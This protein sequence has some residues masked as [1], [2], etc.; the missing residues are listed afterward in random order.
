[1]CVDQNWASYDPLPSSKRLPNKCIKYAYLH[2]PHTVS[3]KRSLPSD[4]AAF[5]KNF[6][7][8]IRHAFSYSLSSHPSLPPLPASTPSPPSNPPPISTLLRLLLCQCLLIYF[9]F[10][11]LSSSS[12]SSSFYSTTPVSAAS[13]SSPFHHLQLL[14]QRLLIYFLF[15]GAS[16]ASSSSSSVSLQLRL[17]VFFFFHLRLFLQLLILFH[18]LLL[19]RIWILILCQIPSSYAKASSSVF[20]RVCSHRAF[21]FIT[22]LYISFKKIAFNVPRPWWSNFKFIRQPYVRCLNK[23]RKAFVLFYL[24]QRLN[25]KQ[26]LLMNGRKQNLYNHHRCGLSLFN[27][28]T[29]G[30]APTIAA[31]SLIDL[32]QT[33][34][35]R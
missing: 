20:C 10:I 8:H 3:Y 13:K 5:N 32:N 27:L 11:V 25:A 17:L 29:Q 22:L 23:N 7:S 21:L 19:L 9:F 28:L 14:C 12:F 6:N 31:T 15:I 26:S 2:L 1:M 33:Y 24:Q 16:T 4:N 35:P 34:L 30:A 18:H